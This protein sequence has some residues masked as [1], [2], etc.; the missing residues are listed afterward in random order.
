MDAGN[1]LKLRLFECRGK[2][3]ILFRSS[4]IFNRQNHGSYPTNVG[5]TL[6]YPGGRKS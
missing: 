3:L 6:I 4:P 2:E 5:E 1:A